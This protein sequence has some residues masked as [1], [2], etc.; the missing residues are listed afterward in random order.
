MSTIKRHD[1]LA[2]EM[3]FEEEI[4]TAAPAEEVEIVSSV[5]HSVSEA[6]KPVQVGARARAK[7]LVPAWR[8]AVRPGLTGWT[9]APLAAR[10][11]HAPRPT[12]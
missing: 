10:R 3:I 6:E 8:R 11:P 1:T 9:R 5:K 2:S 4:K 7:P 12:T